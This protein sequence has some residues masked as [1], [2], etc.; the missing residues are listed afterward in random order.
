MAFTGR[1]NPVTIVHTLFGALLQLVSTGGT[2]MAGE[3]TVIEFESL[4]KTS[5]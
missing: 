4:L 1:S 2:A 5:N 3:S